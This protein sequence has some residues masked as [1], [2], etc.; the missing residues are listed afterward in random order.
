MNIEHLLQQ[1]AL[2]QALEA[3]QA[4]LQQSQHLE[5]QTYVGKDYDLAMA[6][7]MVGYVLKIGD[8]AT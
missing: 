7:R 1:G 4:L 8:S 2:Q 3:S 5:E 6:I